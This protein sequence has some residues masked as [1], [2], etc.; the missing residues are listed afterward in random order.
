ME[1]DKLIDGKRAGEITGV[2]SPAHRYAL[3]KQNKFPQ[4]VKVGHRTRFIERECYAFSAERIAERDKS[5]VAK[6][7]RDKRGRY[8]RGKP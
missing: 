7:E 5:E 6:R 8:K 4:P 3:I 1:Q 2:K